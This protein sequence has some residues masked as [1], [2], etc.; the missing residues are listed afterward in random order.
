MLCNIFAPYIKISYKKQFFMGALCYTVN[1]L[2]QIPNMLNTIGVFLMILGSVVGGA[3]AAVIWVSQGG[4]VVTLLQKYQIQQHYKGRYFGILN[5]IVFSNILFGSLVTTF[6]LGFLPDT[7]YF[8]ILAGFG[9]LSIIL[10]LFLL[11][12]VQ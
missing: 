6:V 3:G 11:E 8:T 1:Y 10:G 5:M 4:F 9:G 2:L 12:D 7:Q